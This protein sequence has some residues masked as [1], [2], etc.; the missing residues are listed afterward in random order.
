M[1]WGMMAPFAWKKAKAFK[2]E[3]LREGLDNIASET[4]QGLISLEDSVN[5]IKAY[6]WKFSMAGA[7]GIG[8]SVSGL[9]MGIYLITTVL[10]RYGVL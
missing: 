6:T 10:E 4:K 5:A 2:R 1:A 8:L 7:T 3:S 9:C